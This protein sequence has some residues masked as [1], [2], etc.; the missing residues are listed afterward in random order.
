MKKLLYILNQR[1]PT[2]KAYG[3]QVANMCSAFAAQG[4]A[5]E[6]VIPARNTRLKDNLYSYYGVPETFAV[7]RISTLDFYLPGILDRLAFLGKQWLSAWKLVRH[8]LEQKPDIIYT[9]DESVAWL[10]SWTIRKLC[11]EAHTFSR[12]RMLVYRRL[13]KLGVRVIVINNAL[14][15]EFEKIGMLSEL[16]LVSPDGVDISKFDIPITQEAARQKVELPLTDKIV[17]YTGHLFPWKGANVLAQAA[18]EFPGVLFVFVGGMPVDVENFRK[19]FGGQPNIRIIGQRPYTQIPYYLKAADVLVL[20][21]TSGEAISKSYTSPLKLFEYMASNRPIVASDLSSI[22]EVLNEQ[23]AY[24]VKPDDP[25]TLANGIRQA[26][27]DSDSVKL[28]KKARSDVEQYTWSIRAAG[29]ISFLLRKHIVILTLDTDPKGGYGRYASELASGISQNGYD[30]LFLK[31][32]GSGQSGVVCLKRRFGMFLSA[33]KVRKYFRQADIVHA[34]D[35]YPYGIIAW[36]GN[37]FLNRPLVLTLQGTYSITPFY[38][39]KTRWLACHALQAAQYRIAIS[40]FTKKSVQNIT[41]TED[42]EVINHGIDLGRFER[43]RKSSDKKFILSVGALK[44]RKGYHIAIPAF[45]LAKEKV[46]DLEYIIVGDQ[47]DQSYYQKLRALVQELRIFEAVC[48]K[49][50]ITDQE[51]ADLYA[52]AYLFLLPSI[53]YSHHIEGFGLVFLE[54][55]AAGLPVIGTLGNGIEDAVHNGVN[56]LL[57]EQGDINQTAQAIVNIV[58]D[59]DRW[60]KMSAASYAWA[61]QHDLSQVL[62]RYDTVYRQL[63]S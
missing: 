20:P 41:A 33:W 27:S 37:I 53:N 31:E 4:C 5:V 46:P 28:T 7:R 15:R 52:Q 61:R 44:P 50:H 18:R 38:N 19:Q 13:R 23:N 6:L 14:K 43:Q 30:I 16:I 10:A 22:R 49:S 12:N 9:R 51:L 42:I 36:L 1:M 48:F 58:G 11:F 47:Q 62:A 45:A 29:V 55:A 21:N 60:Q 34:L 56:G 35:V 63:L 24:I 32:R 39:P 40:Q 26:L 54:A 8:A 17:M 25:C 2:E 3:I 57:V 59:P